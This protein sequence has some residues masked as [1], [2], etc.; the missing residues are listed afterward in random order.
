[1]SCLPS[2]LRSFPSEWNVSILEEPVSQ[3]VP[4]HQGPVH[5]HERV[6]KISALLIGFIEKKDTHCCGDSPSNNRS[7]ELV[8]RSYS[9]RNYAGAG[10]RE[11][12]VWWVQVSE[13]QSPWLYNK[14]FTDCLWLLEPF[15][16]LLSKAQRLFY[17]CV[18]KGVKTHSICCSH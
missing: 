13:C 18:S 15:F 12:C 14:H 2:S 17:K 11:V 3:Q 7:P 16:H 1:M 4:T 5:Y 6:N 9:R 10:V 8:P